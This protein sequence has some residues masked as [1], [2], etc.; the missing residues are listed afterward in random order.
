M[1]T[2]IAQRIQ[3]TAPAKPCEH[4]P[5]LK[6]TNRHK[7][8]IDHTFTMQLVHIAPE[9]Y[10]GTKTFCSHMKTFYSLIVAINIGTLMVA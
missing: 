1:L 7:I 8:R 6:L 4:V 9:R 5:Q 10:R 2:F 3:L